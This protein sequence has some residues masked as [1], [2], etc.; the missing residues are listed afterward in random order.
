MKTITFENKEA[1][2]TSTKPRKNCITDDD[3]NDIK[4]AVNENSNINVYSNDEIV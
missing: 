2:K 3:I 1:T 4:E